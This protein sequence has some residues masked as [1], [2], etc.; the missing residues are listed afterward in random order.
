MWWSN[1]FARFRSFCADTWNSETT[2]QPFKD[3]RSK[4][5]GGWSTSQSSKMIGILSY[6]CMIF[7]VFSQALIS[8]NLS[9]NDLR[10]EGVKYLAKAL[11]SNEVRWL[12]FSNITS[13]S[14]LTCSDTHHSRSALQQSGWRRS[15]ILVGCSD[16]QSRK[17]K[18]MLEYFRRISLIPFRH[19]PLSDWIVTT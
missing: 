7:I 11:E 5:S 2:W 1:T 14:S 3:Q 10:A 13:P 9:S 19:S 18:D 8:L 16:K 15:E 6:F 17:I 12:I 4:I